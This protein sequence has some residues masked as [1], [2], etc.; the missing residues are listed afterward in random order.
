MSDELFLQ[1]V[2]ERRRSHLTMNNKVVDNKYRII[3]NIITLILGLT[4]PR[5]T[6]Q[7]PPLFQYIDAFNPL[8]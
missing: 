4:R 7:N 8:Y 3:A 6:Q 5:C 2:D 1:N